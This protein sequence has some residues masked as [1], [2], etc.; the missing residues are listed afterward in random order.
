MPE[1]PTKSGAAIDSTVLPVAESPK[2]VNRVSSDAELVTPMAT[3][4]LP[5]GALTADFDAALDAFAAGLLI[6]VDDEI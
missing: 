1:V 2:D 4:Q 5:S 3:R 6:C